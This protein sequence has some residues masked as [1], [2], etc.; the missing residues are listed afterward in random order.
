[1][2]PLQIL[3]YILQVMFWSA[4]LCEQIY[5]KVIF[6]F[7]FIVGDIIFIY[8]VFYTPETVDFFSTYSDRVDYDSKSLDDTT[9][10]IIPHIT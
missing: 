8:N 3:F 9:P 4:R 5:E 7:T 1:L 6:L 2:T 10:T